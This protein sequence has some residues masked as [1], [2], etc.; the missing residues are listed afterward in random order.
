MWELIIGLLCC[1]GMAGTLF[2][3]LQWYKKKY[4]NGKDPSSLSS[5]FYKVGWKFRVLLISLCLWMIYPVL[6]A[7]GMYTSGGWMYYAPYTLL[8]WGK[9]AFAIAIGGI[10]GVAFNAYGNYEHENRPHVIS[11]GPIAAAAS[12][13][14]CLLRHEWYIALGIWAAWA[15]Y[16][17][18]KNYK[19]NKAGNKNAWGLYSEL[20]AF[21]SVPTCLAVFMTMNY[22]F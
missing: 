19:N 20:I 15:I 7:N 12:A 10:I 3:Y 5:T 11:A 18:W 14:G 22:F 13:L 9:L 8:G 1:L 21:Y 17:V 6:L 2:G 16:Y 4:K